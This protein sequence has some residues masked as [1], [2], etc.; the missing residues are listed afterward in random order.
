MNKRWL[1]LLAVLLAFGLLAAACGDSDDDDAGDDGGDAATEETEAP[2]DDAGDDGG[3]DATE[4]TEA[5]A[6]DDGGEAASG[7]GV[8]LEWMTRPDNPEEAA[9]YDAISTQLNGELDGVEL[10][11]TPGSNEGNGYQ[12]TLLT[13]LSAGTAPDVFWIP[14]TDIADFASRGVILDMRE[15]ADAAGHSDA[16]FYPGPMA[17][18]TTELETG[19]PGNALWGLPRDVSTFGLYLNLDLIAEAGAPNPIELEAAG[20]WTWDAFLEV[21]EA[22]AALDTS[23]FGYAQANWWG[24]NGA[25]MNAAGGGFF[26]DDRTACGLDADGSIE[27]LTFLRDLY[28]S[29]VAVPFGED[30]EAPFRAGQV[31]MFQNGRWATPGIRTVDFNFDVVGLPAGPSGGPG[32][33]LFWGAYVV[34]ADTADPAAAWELVANLTRA[35]VQAQ[36][37][38]LGANIPS[39]VSQEALDAFLTFTPPEN[40][41]AFLDGLA[42]DPT[43]EGPLWAGSWPEFDGL[44]GTEIGAVVTG[45]RDIDDFAANICSEVAPAFGG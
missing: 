30:P 39:R 19:Q 33:W 35:D 20:E 12:Q 45:D 13:N 29:D 16:D 1:R 24:P 32:N 28:A 36:I 2:A 8:A 26:N 25:W 27:G 5:P 23:I 31:G 38:E 15:F 17:Q 21:A 9:V 18:L 14:G 42:N 3:D 44:A 41:Q 40:N 11:Y 7:D 43:T 6:D 34:N 37:S 22:V 4:E 10:T